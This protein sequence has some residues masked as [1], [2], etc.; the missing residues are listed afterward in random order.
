MDTG[1]RR[2]DEAGIRRY[3]EAGIGMA[4]MRFD[5]QLIHQYQAQQLKY[6]FR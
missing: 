3:D 5:G 1:I 4:G 2:Y 6:S